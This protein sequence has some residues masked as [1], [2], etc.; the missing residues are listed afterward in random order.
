LPALSVIKS[1]I[2][3][4]VNGSAA[5]VAWVATIRTESGPPGVG[6]E[7]VVLASKVTA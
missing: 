6:E 2:C 7:V 4:G 3:V 1:V 5:A